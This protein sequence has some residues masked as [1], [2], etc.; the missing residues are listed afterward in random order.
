MS[1]YNNPEL[2]AKEANIT[3]EQA[4]IRCTYFRKLEELNYLAKKC[5]SCGQHTLTFEEGSYEEGYG[6]YIYCDNDKLIQTENGEEYE[7]D[8]EFT[9][10][11]EK[12]YEA[13]CDVRDL[14]VV[15]MFGFDMQKS[16]IKEFEAMVGCKWSEFVENNTKRDCIGDELHEAI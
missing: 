3:L 5:P 15:L 6:S 9:S 7:S 8:C 1:I 16:D 10:D 12:S 11:V 2:Y 4:E 14:D 13:I